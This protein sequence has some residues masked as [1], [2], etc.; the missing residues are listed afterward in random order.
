[1]AA[2]EHRYSLEEYR[3]AADELLANQTEDEVA[4]SVPQHTQK[5]IT[6]SSLEVL[7]HRREL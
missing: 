4:E 3:R 1:M 2:S 6:E 5:L 7:R